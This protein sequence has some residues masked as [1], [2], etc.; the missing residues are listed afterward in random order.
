[1][2]EFVAKE[3]VRIAEGLS[4]DTELVLSDVGK[5]DSMDIRRL[6]AEIQSEMDRIRHNEGVE[7]FMSRTDTEDGVRISI[8]VSDHEAKEAIV[9]HLKS[10]ADRFCRGL[11][12]K[13]GFTVR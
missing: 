4:V 2:R 8:G 9:D 6:C 10:R 5:D 3:L 12:V 7:T 11:G 13:V 1:M